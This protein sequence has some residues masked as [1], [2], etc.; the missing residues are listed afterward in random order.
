MFD[1]CLPGADRAKTQFNPCFVN[2][3]LQVHTLIH[4]MPDNTLSRR[5]VQVQN[6]PIYEIGAKFVLS[7]VSFSVKT[8]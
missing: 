3:C 6:A 1:W 8:L 5:I 7:Y 4:L 2:L